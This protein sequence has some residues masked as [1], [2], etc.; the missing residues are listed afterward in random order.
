MADTPL[1]T[2]PGW[3]GDQVAQLKKVWITTAEQVSALGATEGGVRSL[4]EQLDTSEE[5]VRRLI[6]S[7]RAV[8]P[9]A[10]RAELERAADTSDYGLGALRP[11][12]P[13]K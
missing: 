8:L 6:D 10:V 11:K 9:P 3:S 4:S 2:V 12:H 7:A 5:E 1:E 13:R